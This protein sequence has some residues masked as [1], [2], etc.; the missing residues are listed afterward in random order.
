MGEP[1]ADIVEVGA[2]LGGGHFQ[3]DAIGRPRSQWT[4]EIG[5]P[6]I[7]VELVIRS[8][9][10]CEVIGGQFVFTATAGPG[11]EEP[12]GGTTKGFVFDASIRRVEFSVGD[13]VLS[14]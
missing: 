12:S 3:A 8:G 9:E 14:G 7:A 6:V 10:H 1:K 5:L 2:D 11:G 13:Q 4:E